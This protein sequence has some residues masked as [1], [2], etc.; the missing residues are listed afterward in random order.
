LTLQPADRGD[1]PGY[2]LGLL[3]EIAEVE[4][5]ANHLAALA[6]DVRSDGRHV[7]A[8]ANW[9]GRAAN[10]FV[11]RTGSVADWVESPARPLLDLVDVMRAFASE[12]AE[13]QHRASTAL[14]TIQAIGAQPGRQAELATAEEQLA[15]AW[16]Q[17]RYAA[18]N[19]QAAVLAICQALREG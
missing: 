1:I 6:G 7:L 4:R 17:T 5:M 3:K 10:A 19:A 8:R 14:W 15:A 18:S 11:T 16:A 9:T 2:P 13:A 12:L